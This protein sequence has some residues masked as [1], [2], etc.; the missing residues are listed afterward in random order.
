[1]SHAGN[2]VCS[3]GSTS[4]KTLS[5]RCARTNS[6]TATA[7]RCV[8]EGGCV[9]GT[10]HRHTPQPPL[11][12]IQQPPYSSSSCP[13]SDDRIS[14]RDCSIFPRLATW[15]RG[16]RGA[17]PSPGGRHRACLH[18]HQLLGH[19][20][21]PRG[22]PAAGAVDVFYQ[23]LRVAT[24]APVF[25]SIFYMCLATL[26]PTTLL[27]AH[28]ALRTCYSFLRSVDAI[29]IHEPA[30]VFDAHPRLPTC[31][32]ICLRAFDHVLIHVFTRTDAYTH[33][34]LKLLR[35]LVKTTWP[36]FPT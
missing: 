9:T 27:C 32:L 29:L 10:V 21:T 6:S 28:V 12:L 22:D 4:R 31:L 14:F 7:S 33:C 25:L 13:F 34:V 26:Q 16:N 2:E 8:R 5:L 36:I 17:R 35:S 11:L 1:M 20:L 23:F 24:C 18:G 15:L 30:R 19:Q 3:L